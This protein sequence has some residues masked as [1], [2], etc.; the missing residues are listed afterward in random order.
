MIGNGSASG[1]FGRRR[2]LG[3]W[4]E[5]EERRMKEEEE[6]GWLAFLCLILW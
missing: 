5:E 2:G 6:E 3:V 1:G 4:E